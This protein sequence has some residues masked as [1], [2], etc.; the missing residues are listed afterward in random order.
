MLKASTKGTSAKASCHPEPLQ[1]RLREGSL[2]INEILRGACPVLDTGLSM[3]LPP[4]A[5]VP[6]PGCIITW[7]ILYDDLYEIRIFVIPSFPSGQA[8]SAAKAG[9]GFSV[10]A[11]E[12]KNLA[13]Q[14]AKATTQISAKVLQIQKISEATA[15]A[16]RE[17]STVISKINDISTTI[18]AAIVQ[19][20]ASTSEIS[21]SC[22]QV[23]A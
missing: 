22:S 8:L 20:G 16:M 7:I 21:R 19:Q 13:N 23:A 6:I 2:C 1:D 18:S 5:E 14:T 15:T 3:T 12:V 11:S 10:V 17:I 4:F 9:K